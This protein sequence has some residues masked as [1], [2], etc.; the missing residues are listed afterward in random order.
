MA[1]ELPFEYTYRPAD[2]YRRLVPNPTAEQLEAIHAIEQN[3]RDLE[4]YL[5]KIGAGTQGG[6][7]NFELSWVAAGA[8]VIESPLL[9][10]LITADF[11]KG[12]VYYPGTVPA[13]DFHLEVDAILVN[14]SETAEFFFTLAQTG[15]LIVTS[16][17][18]I[19]TK[20]AGYNGFSFH[21]S[22][23]AGGELT[24]RNA[25]SSDVDT[26]NV[27]SFFPTSAGDVMHLEASL[28]GT[29]FTVIASS[30]VGSGGSDSVT[31]TV[32]GFGPDIYT[33][34]LGESASADSPWQ[35]SNLSA[36]SF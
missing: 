4:D 32:S 19:A 33:A 6:S 23:T 16:S 24:M 21:M 25:S 20:L 14:G 7:A 1:G 27:A 11:Q 15:P 9:A 2:L 34:F 30:S 12:S 28:T 8:S 10:S 22:S 29:T 5:R 18:N 13:A 17:D 36:L 31:Q 3:H 26:T 35:I